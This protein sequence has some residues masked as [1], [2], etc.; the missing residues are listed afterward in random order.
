M[1][2]FVTDTSS[3]GE[4]SA[5]RAAVPLP[6]VFG[7]TIL[8]SACL[9]FLVQPLA[10]KL[11][12]PWFGGSAAVWTTCMLFFQAG[13][14]LGYLYAHGLVTSL[15]PKR[16][17]T[18]HTILLAASLLTLPIL[19]NSR[20]QPSPGEDPTWRV[21]G[22]LAASVGLP[23][24]LLSST[25]PLLQSWFTR[26]QDGAL[27]YRYFAL[28]NAGS[29]VALLSYPILIEP[30]LTGHQQA[31]FWSGA[32][33]LFVILCAGTAWLAVTLPS[34]GMRRRSVELE[35]AES[36][37]PPTRFTILLWL[38]LPACAS[39]LLLAVTNLLT[40]NIAPMPF[41]WVLPLSLYLLTFILCFESSRWYKRWLFLA[42]L[43][44]ALAFLGQASGP[45]H[46]EAIRP[47]ILVLCSA[48]F[49]T[50]MCCH[51]ELAK[52]RP[53]VRRLTAYYLCLSGGGVIGGL[54][55]A[56]LA[57]HWFSAYYEYPIIFCGCALLLLAVAWRDYGVWI[58]NKT[59]LP[60]WVFTFVATAFL[61]IYV[62]RQSYEN[63][64]D[65]RL[66]V[67]NFYGALRVADSRNDDQ[68]LER[69]LSHG[70]ITHGIQFLNPWLRRTPTTYYS[71]DSGI[72]LTWRTLAATGPLKM[73]VVGLGAGTLAAYGRQGDTIRFYE[74]NPQVVSI[75][76]TQF[77]FLSDSP[78]RHDVLLGDAR[79][80]LAR[81]PSQQFDILTIDAF[82]GDA[83][84][85]HLLT[86]EAFQIYWR[87]L[88]PDGVLAVHVSNRYIALA[89]VAEMAAREMGKT[90]RQVENVDDD[91]LET[92]A[93]SYVLITSRAGFFDSPLFK[94]VATK[95]AVP[96]A[97]KMW[98]DDFSNL[99]QAM[100]FK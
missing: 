9:L 49:V 50:C 83:I 46:F 96:P 2:S 94:E 34:S 11:I 70:T 69:D 16:Q 42:L 84:P 59:G 93:S 88:K 4:V 32:Y 20:W 29:L 90:A 85:V 87:H 1:S 61:M 25:S 7:S 58:R 13:L 39:A 18:V 67:R 74:I 14:L 65:A 97:M 48:L 71:P 89:P 100:Q 52:L 66:L 31:W 78:A 62:C 43:L 17:A 38:A 53:G 24:L 63:T 77:S 91:K 10:S 47:M 35:M 27:P 79:L 40:Q 3:T 5:T 33:A 15:H 8:A 37:T 36:D 68:T 51:G 26:T 98:T 22:V 92:Y 60:I 81:Q 76:N 75:A 19:P 80:V 99:W 82:S 55:V 21:F 6:V 95:I 73:G 41:L 28:S 23:Y 72:G 56:L 44:P 86:R 45:E 57:P 64:E 12:L 54:F 30:Y